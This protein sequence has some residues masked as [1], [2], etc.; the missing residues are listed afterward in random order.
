MVFGAL[1]GPTAHGKVPDAG[2]HQPCYGQSPET[3][4]LMI[5]NGI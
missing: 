3:C 2:D 5:L 1:G 4:S